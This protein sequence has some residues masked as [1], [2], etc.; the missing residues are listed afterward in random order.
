MVNEILTHSPR[1]IFPAMPSS[2]ALP[3]GYY[4]KAAGIRD[5]DRRRR[6]NHH[7]AV[8]I[9]RPARHGAFGANKKL[10]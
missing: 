5:L 3:I 1:S 7:V 8:G 10:T 4:L 2:N 9:E 6:H